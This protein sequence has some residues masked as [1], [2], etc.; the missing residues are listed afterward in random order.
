MHQNFSFTFAVMDCQ[1]YDVMNFA[2]W[3]SSFLQHV[4]SFDD[5]TKDAPN[6]TAQLGAQLL[7]NDSSLLSNGA[8]LL[9]QPADLLLQPLVL[10]LSLLQCSFLKYRKKTRV[11]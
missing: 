6:V 11:V 2:P 7:Q 8:V 1:R 10:V 9:L 3:F 5:V 4:F